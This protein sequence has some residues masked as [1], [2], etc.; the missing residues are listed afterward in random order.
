MTVLPGVWVPEKKWPSAVWQ[1]ERSE[2]SPRTP[3]VTARL[4]LLSAFSRVDFCTSF[5][6]HF[7]SV[8]CNQVHHQGQGAASSEIC[9]KL[10]DKNVNDSLRWGFTLGAYCGDWMYFYGLLRL[11][12]F[13]GW[14]CLV[15]SFARRVAHTSMAWS[16]A[17]VSSMRCFLGGVALVLF[18]LTFYVLVE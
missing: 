12:W 5:T 7:P 2:G 17:S 10:G 15:W 1:A 8:V 13:F 18:P 11:L 16:C 9:G 3:M 6:N 4:A 14:M